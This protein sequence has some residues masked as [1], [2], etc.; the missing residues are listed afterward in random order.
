MKLKRAFNDIS[1]GFSITWKASRT[2]ALY[3]LSLSFI[4]SLLPLVSLWLIKQIIDIVTKYENATRQDFI[5]AIITLVIVQLIQAGVQQAL[6]DIQTVQQQ[7]VID[8][9]SKKVLEKAVSVEYPYYENAAYFNSLHIAQQEVIFRTGTLTTSINQLLQS[10]LTML[11]LSVVFLQFSW[12]YGVLVIAASIPV[13]IVKW[14]HAKA[15]QELERQNITNDRKAVYL[16]RILTDAAHAKEVRTY[17]YGDFFIEKFSELRQFIFRGKKRLSANQAWSETIIQGIEIVILAAIIYNLGTRTLDGALSAGAFIFYL[18]ALQRIQ[19]GFKNFI[20]AFTLLYRQHFFLHHI[21]TFLDIPVTNH[22]HERRVLFPS[23]INNGLQLSDVSFSYPGSTTETLS[24]I[25]IR[26]QPGKVTAIIGENG[27][28]KS[29]LAKLLTRLYTP[30]SGTICIDGH[31]IAD[32][33][34]GI[35]TGKVSMLFQDY[36]QYHFSLGDNIRLSSSKDETKLNSSA[37]DADLEA[38]TESLPGGYDT[39]LGKMFG[40]D[41][42]LSGGQWQKIA[43]ARML[44]KDAEILIMDEPT[45]NIDPLAEYEILKKITERKKDRIVILITHRLHNLKFADH[46]YLMDHGKVAGEGTV[47]ELLATNMLFR[48]MYER[49]DLERPAVD[50]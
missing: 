27:C 49:Q 7:L 25:N 50:V 29:T 45:S 17:A 16:S 31:N 44:Y 46:I 30:T 15:V 9:L 22:G 42:Q 33:D 34:P 10:G 28:G 5:Y 23:R 40:N 39:V 14:K 24:N 18:Q 1:N 2:Y 35:Y 3:N 32:I 26:F 12:W 8:H 20:S 43:V 36:N 11:M 21:F 41:L 19:S 47:D 13:L 48:Q 4:I 38:L 37:A 6:N